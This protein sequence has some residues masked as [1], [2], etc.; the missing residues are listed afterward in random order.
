MYINHCLSIFIKR[1][2]SFFLILGREQYIWSY[3]RQSLFNTT[4]RIKLLFIVQ[5][6]LNRNPSN[7]W[8]K[9]IQIAIQIE[10]LHGTKFLNP[11]RNLDPDK[12]AQCKPGIKV[13]ECKSHI[14]IRTLSYFSKIS[15]QN[16]TFIE[17]LLYQ[18]S[19]I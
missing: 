13:E 8:I 17:S 11:D 4:K 5:S 1:N 16:Y 15:I 19:T 7:I 9:I 6:L 3:T 10:C 18:E 14:L 2:F 12:F